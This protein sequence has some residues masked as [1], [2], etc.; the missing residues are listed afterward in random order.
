MKHLSNIRTLAAGV[1]LVMATVLTAT[2]ATAA[3]VSADQAVPAVTRA[4]TSAQRDS[5]LRLYKAYFLRAPDAKGHGHWAEQ[6]ASGTMSLASI[7]QFFSQSKEFQTR[8]GSLSNPQFTALIYK[9]VLA[10]TPD[11]TG[12]SYWV[13]RLN[14]GA[15]RGSM[16]I[17]FSESPEFQRATKTLPPSAPLTW[18]A[19][20]LQLTNAERTSRGLR[21]L[22]ACRP[23]AVAAQG[24]SAWQAQHQVMSHTGVNGSSHAD[25]MT[26]AGYRW[27]W[28]GENVA[29]GDV[30]Y[31]VA[32]VVKA[33][34]DSPAHRANILSTNYVHI[35][36]G[37]SVAGNG[38]VHWTQNFGAGG[39]C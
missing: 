12:S 4:A 9:N 28:A 10:R 29:V 2:T 11:Q 5:I 34:M 3:P 39:A 18:D 17:G 38:A 31:T 24:H 33:W 14:Q 37:R 30:S 27:N 21:A 7:S 20:M 23:I 6:Y 1:V 35:G 8:Y 15:S 26:W 13:Q 36:F 32:D 22:V 16:M 19:Q 25:R